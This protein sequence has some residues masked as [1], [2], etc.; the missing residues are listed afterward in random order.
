VSGRFLLDTN[1]V[2]AL[3][4]GDVTVQKNL[5]RAE[6]VF[7]PSIVLGELY[8]DAHK[9]GQSEKNLAQ[10]EEF[11][12]SITVLPCDAGTA[13]EYGLIKDRLRRK[14]QPVPENDLWIAA[15]ARQHN[16]VLVTRD[17]H[18]AGIEGLEREEW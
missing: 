4:R 14:G 8:Y 10:I 9:S 18:F 17:P 1:I 16:I 5:A 2:I 3:F 12:G 7:I 15:V 13:L 11:A 6:R